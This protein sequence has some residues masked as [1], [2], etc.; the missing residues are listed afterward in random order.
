M[1]KN[2][3][4]STNANVE[5]LCQYLNHTKCLQMQNIKRNGIKIIRKN[6]LS[7]IYNLNIKQL[8]GNQHMNII[9]PK[10]RSNFHQIPHQQIYIRRLCLKIGRASCRERV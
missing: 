2:Y 10:K 9:G 5:I 6:V 4:K 7:T 3:F 1:P 8:I